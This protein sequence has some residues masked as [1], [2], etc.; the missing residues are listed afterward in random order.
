MLFGTEI[1]RRRRDL[2]RIW[3]SLIRGLVIEVAYSAVVL[4]RT[5]QEKIQQ[6]LCAF[7]LF[8]LWLLRILQWGEDK[9]LD[10]MRSNFGKLAVFWILQAV[11]VWTV[12][13]PVTLVNASDNNPSIQV[14]DI[15][16]WIMWVV[17]FTVQATADQQKLAFENS[18]DNRGRWCNVGLWKYFRHPNYCGEGCRF[19]YGGVENLANKLC[20]STT[21]GL[22][23]TGDLLTRRQ[24]IYGINK[25]TESEARSFWVFVW[26][27]LQDITLMILGVCAFV[28]LDCWHN[29][30][31]MADGAHDGLG[32]VAKI[33]L[34]VFVTKNK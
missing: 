30:R 23:A 34:V 5:L 13:L 33:L 28:S 14:V 22:A 29:Y 12:S 19:S 15:V 26:E 17:G 20:T 2:K 4:I 1:W 8:E 3:G 27:A 32:I 7:N 18:T 9:R 25:F 11:W 24:Q 31:R 6:L 10:K 21:N 16:G